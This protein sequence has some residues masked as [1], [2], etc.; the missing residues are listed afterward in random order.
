[1]AL[2]VLLQRAPFGL[3]ERLSEAVA[4]ALAWLLSKQRHDGH[5]LG[6]LGA[7]TTLES[8]Y[9]FYLA[10]LREPARVHRLA[11]RIRNRQLTTRT[12]REPLV[13]VQPRE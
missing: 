2:K 7:D 5:W 10:V 9:I 8:D 13:S 12:A 6:E 4:R 11:E 1:M 3:E